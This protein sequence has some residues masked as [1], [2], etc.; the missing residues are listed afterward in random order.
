[1]FPDGT[2]VHHGDDDGLVTEVVE[3]EVVYACE[4]SSDD[5]SASENAEQNIEEGEWNCFFLYA[6]LPA[7]AMFWLTF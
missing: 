5:S 6:K 4:S 2:I 3:E 1:M 7:N